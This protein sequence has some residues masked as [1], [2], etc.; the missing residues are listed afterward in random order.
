MFYGDWVNLC[1]ARSQ[2]GKT[3]ER[4]LMPNGKAGMFSDG[5]QANTRDAMV[6]RDGKTWHCY[7]TAIHDNVGANYCRSSTDRRTWSAPKMVARGGRAGNGPWS[8]E[9]PQVIHKAGYW[10]LFRTQQ[11][12]GPP[13]TRVYRSKDPMHF[14]IDNDDHF[15]CVLEVAAPEIFQHE[16]QWYIAALLPDVQGIRIS[17]LTWVEDTH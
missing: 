10:Y 11:Y 3:F 12:S 1:I 14:G 13:T 7:Y 2:D 9:C 17:T 15:V 16:G 5:D 4:W 8:A 6:V